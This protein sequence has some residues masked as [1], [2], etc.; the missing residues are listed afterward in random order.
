MNHKKK[1]RRGRGLA[2]DPCLDSSIPRFTNSLGSNPSSAQL[3]HVQ[4]F[5]D[6]FNVNLVSVVNFRCK[7]C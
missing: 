5:N 6:D 2:L 4:M 1:V 7:L 3:A